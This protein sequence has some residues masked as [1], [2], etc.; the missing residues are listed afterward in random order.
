MFERELEIFIHGPGGIRRLF[1]YRRWMFLA[2]LIV[3]ASL[4]VGGAWLWRFQSGYEALA[5]RRQAVLGELAAQKAAAMRLRDRM[6][7]VGD[8]AGRIAS[9]NA[10]LGVMLDQPAADRGVMGGVA[11]PRLPGVAADEHLGRRLFAFLEAVGARLA[12]EEVA[13]Q[14]LAQSLF[15]RKLEFLAKPTLWPARGFI[16]SGFG[17]RP[18]PFGRGGDFHNGVDIKV[19]IGSPVYAA[20]AGRVTEADTMS[21]YGLRVVISHDYGLETVY[22]HLKKSEVRPGQQVRRGQLIALSGNSGRTTGSHLHYEVRVGGA[23][24]NPRQYLLD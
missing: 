9:F 13:Q 5:V 24:V 11:V 22:A 4:A 19:P 1:V 14:E 10:K 16:T 15:D 12:R 18:S 17:S 8:E 21:G 20:G 7:R 6:R 2:P 3:L 23:P